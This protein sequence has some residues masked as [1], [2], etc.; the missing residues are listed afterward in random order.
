M[1]ELHNCH[2]TLQYFVMGFWKVLE[3]SKNE[4][5]LI[6][7]ELIIYW[8]G[9]SLFDTKVTKAHLSLFCIKFTG[10]V[11]I[12]LWLRKDQ[13]KSSMG[14]NHFEVTLLMFMSNYK[15]NASDSSSEILELIVKKW[16]WK[17]RRS[18]WKMQNT[19]SKNYRK[20]V[21]KKFLQK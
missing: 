19:H 8:T 15:G 12:R 6:T 20:Q 18:I 13:I 2:R 17:G 10:S 5:F 3:S 11:V 9:Y 4:N 1:S 21:I 7:F 14:K 16:I